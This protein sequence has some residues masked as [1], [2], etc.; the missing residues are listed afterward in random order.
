MD[1][2]VLDPL[3]NITSSL[4]ALTTS[5]TTTNTFT[6]APTATQALLS[7]DDALSSA[8]ATLKKHQDNYAHILHLRSEALRLEDQIKDTIRQCNAYTSDI[9]AVS[10][11]ILED[12]DSDDEEDEKGEV[13][14]NTLLTLASR[15]STY[16]VAAQRE[17][18]TSLQRLRRDVQTNG[19]G[20]AHAE[21]GAEI[22]GLTDAE[23][24]RDRAM[25]GMA[26]PDSEVLRLGALG[27]LQV[28]REQGGED[29][30]DAEIERLVMESEGE[31]LDSLGKDN[32]ED[33]GEDV[34]H[35]ATEARARRSSQSVRS[36][37]APSGSVQQPQAK[38]LNL[39]LWG[40]DDDDDDD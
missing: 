3:N 4:T 38:K 14:Y 9:N 13:D 34:A 30:V 37:P 16:N 18:E 5:L 32:K 28:I 17:A 12:S 31:G 27:R 40:G 23:I 6:A 7:A 36:A 20:E 25:K 15:I 11:G 29:A 1:Q 26:F 10:P 33:T 21:P 35:T 19:N 2:V 22:T 8:L 39:D 24:A